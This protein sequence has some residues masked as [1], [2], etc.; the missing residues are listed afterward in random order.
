LRLRLHSGLGRGR[1][2]AAV[3]AL[4]LIPVATQLDA[5]GA[6]AIAAALAGAL[7]AYEVT[8]FAQPR[9]QVRAG[10]G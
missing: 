4:A 7:I 3:V 5:L 9:A 10:A 1:L 2:V 6:L 8:R